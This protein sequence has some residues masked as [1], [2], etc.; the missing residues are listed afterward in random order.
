MHGRQP[1]SKPQSRQNVLAGKAT[2]RP[3]GEVDQSWP[4]QRTAPAKF[5]WL[6]CEDRLRFPNTAA[7]LRQ[8]IMISHRWDRL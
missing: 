3:T 6:G 8:C 5:G 7:N 2:E 4:A 1:G